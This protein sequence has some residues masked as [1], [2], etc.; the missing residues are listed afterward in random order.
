M[1][2]LIRILLLL[3]V[4]FSCLGQD[5][6]MPRQGLGFASRQLTPELVQANKTDFASSTTWNFTITSTPIEGNLMVACVGGSQARTVNWPGGWTVVPMVGAGQT[7]EVGYKFAGAG[8]STALTFTFSANLQGSVVY[9]EFNKVDAITPFQFGG[10]A[11]TFSSVTSAQYGSFG[12]TAHSVAIQSIQF[13][14][15]PTW[16]VN[17]GFTIIS[18]GPVR[19]TAAYKVYDNETVG[20]NPTW[21]G[22]SATGAIGLIIFNGKRL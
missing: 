5:M 22:G 13:T 4:S 18:G 19:H 11:T 20:E 6:L 21:S 15:A 14:T 2:A 3:F 9:W 12:V 10:T 16:S 8:E 1:R 7:L 17:G